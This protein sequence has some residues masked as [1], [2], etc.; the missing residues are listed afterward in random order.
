MYVLLIGDLHIPH[1]SLDLPARFKSLLLPGKID[2]VLCT[3]NL[4]TRESLEYLRTIAN[5]VH[6]VRGD[7][8]DPTLSL[9]ESKVIRVGKY[10]FGLCHGHQVIPWGDANALAALQRELDVDVLVTGHTHALSVEKTV[11][12]KLLLNPGTAT[13]AFSPCTLN[14]LTPSFILLNVED[15]SIALFSYTLGDDGVP[16]IDRQSFP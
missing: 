12:G 16:V 3:G 4:N 1:R 9:P 5:D 14:N 13:G 11:D 2:M 10:K 8:D 6:V 7:F 15:E